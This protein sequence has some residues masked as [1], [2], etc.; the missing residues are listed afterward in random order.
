[1]GQDPSE[2]HLDLLK[3]KITLSNSELYELAYNHCTLALTQR[4]SCTPSATSIMKPKIKSTSKS[5]NK[6][7]S[8]SPRP[9]ESSS[10]L[11]AAARTSTAISSF[12]SSIM[13][14]AVTRKAGICKSAPITWKPSSTTSSAPVIRCRLRPAA[15]KAGL[16]RMSTTRRNFKLTS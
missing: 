1:M 3:V 14:R 7:C 15:K 12:V 9:R 16:R 6:P 13:R 8:T 5:T 4:S 10:T 11:P 2:S